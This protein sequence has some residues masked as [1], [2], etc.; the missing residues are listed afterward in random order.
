MTAL[1]EEKPRLDVKIYNESTALFVSNA[2]VQEAFEQCD[3]ESEAFRQAIDERQL[4][5]AGLD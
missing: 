2:Q 5:A 3:D 4:I 1:S